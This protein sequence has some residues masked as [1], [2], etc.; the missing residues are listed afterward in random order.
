[1][2]KVF[3]HSQ[4]KD[5]G[6]SKETI[7][8]EPALVTRLEVDNTSTYIDKDG[9]GNMTF[10]DTVSGTQKL[11]DLVGGG[12]GDVT[13]PASSTDNM[14]ARHHGT[15][16]KTLQDYTSNPPTISDTGD[17]NVDGDVDCD[18]SRLIR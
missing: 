10:T 14:I 1:M 9:D 16:G 6:D 7:D 18:I 3:P 15:A 11:S 12:S 2:T 5:T 13:G 17:M 8:G 4:W